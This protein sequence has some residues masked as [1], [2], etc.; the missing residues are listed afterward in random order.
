MRPKGIIIFKKSDN[1]I[2]LIREGTYAAESKFIGY[3]LDIRLKTNLDAPKNAFLEEDMSKSIID[4]VL[5]NPAEVNKRLTT[6]KKIIKDKYELNDDDFKLIFSSPR[7][8]VSRKQLLTSK[9]L[10]IMLNDMAFNKRALESLI[11]SKTR[12]LENKNKIKVELENKINDTN[13]YI[14]EH[15]TYY[16]KIYD[17]REYYFKQKSDIEKDISDC[18]TEIA[19]NKLKI[20]EHL[21]TFT[22]MM[23]KLKTKKK[24]ETESVETNKDFE[25][26]QNEFV[27]KVKELQNKM[28]EKFQLNNS[29]KSYHEVTSKKINLMK[30]YMEKFVNFNI[31]GEIQTINDSQQAE[32]KENEEKAR[33]AMKEKH[34]LEARQ[35]ELENKKAG[36]NMEIL[37]VKLGISALDLSIS[38]CEKRLQQLNTSLTQY[39][40][41]LLEIINSIEKV[42]ITINKKKDLIS[43]DIWISDGFIKGDIEKSDRVDN[44][45]KLDPRNTLEIA[46]VGIIREAKEE[47]NIN[48]D[49]T[50]MRYIGGTPILYVFEYALNDAEANYLVS[51]QD[52]ETYIEVY[53]MGF[54]TTD[55][56]YKSYGN[57][58]KAS[59]IALDLY[60]GK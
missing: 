5:E 21:A 52:R 54:K 31:V 41:K 46:R 50:R 22:D 38:D 49:E 27:E 23:S 18:N 20:E 2:L 6:A 9:M 26:I 44:G 25:D 13:F 40:N 57:L 35:K 53:P 1:T 58:N 17:D 60:C 48:I 36:Y 19:E 4:Y 42:G 55:E 47:I 3:Y 37:T 56:I 10:F 7:Q 11:E 8:S 30:D 14:E 24:F 32:F 59:K 43:A 51:C 34:Q 15:Q 28:L 12:E 39:Q 29:D 16:D 45:V 33:N